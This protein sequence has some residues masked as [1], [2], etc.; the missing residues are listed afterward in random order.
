[1]IEE[2]ESKYISLREAT[3][4]CKHSQEY[5][6]LRV[7]QGKL[8]ALKFGRNWVTKKEWLEDYLKKVDEYNI[9]INAKKIISPPETLPIRKKPAL[10]LALKSVTGLRFGFVVALT[11][12]LLTTGVVFGK[13]SLRNTFKNLNHYVAELNQSFDKLVFVDLVSAGKKTASNFESFANDIP[14]KIRDAKEL[15]HWLTAMTFG[16][17][18]DYSFEIFKDYGKWLSEAT[19][20]TAKKIAK[21]P[22]IVSDFVGEKLQN[23]SRNTFEGLKSL[24]G[25]IKKIP[26]IVDDSFKNLSK[27]AK[28]SAENLVELIKRIPQIVSQSFRN[29]LKTALEGGKYLVESIKK[30]PQTISQAFKK[31]V[32]RE[33][34]VEKK[35]SE[36]EIEEMK[37]EIKAIK[38]KGLQVREITKEVSRITQIEP[39]KEIT[40]EKIISKIDEESLRILNV[41]IADLQTEVAK[42]LY[43]PGGVIS[44]QIYITQP[45]ASPKIY[46][47]NADIV[48]QAAGSG[49]VILSAAT[50]M[51]ISGSQVVI[52]STSATN[53]LVYIA[54]K[55][56]IDG[57]TEILG[58]LSSGNL[59]AGT[60]VFNAASD[61]TGKVL[62]VQVGG[63]T[64]FSVDNAGAITFT[65]DL[66][67][68]DD[69][70][71]T[72]KL[73]I[74]T[75][76]PTEMLTIVGTSTT[77]LLGVYSSSSAP[78]LYVDTNGNVGIGTSTPGALLHSLSAGTTQL[79]LGYDSSNYQ[80]FTVQSDGSL[81][82]AQDGGS[83]TLALTNGSVGIGTTSPSALLDV[84]SDNSSASGLFRVATGTTEGL[85]VDAAGYVGIGTTSPAYNLT[86]DGQCVTGDTLLPILGVRISDVNLVQIKDIKGGEYVL[87]LNEK[88]G[89]LEPARIKGLLD[90]GVKPIYQLETED[91]KTI[92]T[93]GNHPYLVVQN[94]KSAKMTDSSG[95]SNLAWNSGLPTYSQYS[96]SENLV[97]SFTVDN[98]KALE[99]G[100]IEPPDSWMAIPSPYQVTPRAL[101]LY[102]DDLSWATWTKVIYLEA[103]DEIA[104]A[105]DDLKN[106]EFVKIAK[107]EI[108]AAE[109]VYDIEVEGTHNFVANG[110]IAHN[111]Y[112]SATTTIMGNVGIGTTS[113]SALLDLFRPSTGNIFA[114]S[115]TTAGDLVTIDN[116]GNVGI[117]TTSPS[118]LLDVFSDNSSATGLFRVATGT[119]EGLY[120][121]TAGNVG[122][123]TTTPSANLTLKQQN[124]ADTMILAVRQ[125]DS[126]PSGDFIKYQ[127]V[128]GTDLFRVDN[129][130]NVYQ[131]GIIQSSGSLTITSSSTPQF[132]V[133]QDSSEIT[134]TVSTGGTTTVAVNAPSSPS[135]TFVPQSNSVNTFS[136]ADASENSILSIDTSNR[137]VG[138]GTTSP[139][140]L[141]DVF[142]DGS[143]ASGLF[144]VAT[145]TTEGLYVDTAG[146]VGIGTTSPGAILEVFSDSSSATGL[147][148]VA[149]GTTEAMYITTAGNVGIGTTTPLALLEVFSDN[150][151]ASG[152]FRVATGTTE[153][154]YVD[155]SG[156]VGIGTTSPSALLEVFSDNSSA[157]GLLRVA[158]GTTE[159]LYVDI[160][161]NVGI[162]TAGPGA[163]LDV[164]ISVGSDTAG[165]GGALILGYDN[166]YWI[167]RE[168][169]T[170]LADLAIDRLYGGTNYE[171]MRIQRSTGNV[172]IGTV[173][174]NYKLD[175]NGTIRTNSTFYATTTD[176]D[177][178]TVNSSLSF[179]DNSVAEAD[180]NFSTS[181]G[182]GNHLYISGGNLACEADDDVPESA[183]FDALIRY[184]SFTYSTSTAWTASTTI[185]LGTAYVAETW[186]G[187]QCFTDAGTL[188]V[189][190]ND[191]TNKMN[192]FNA[193]T[194][195]GTVGLTTNNSFT[196]GEKRYVIIGTPATLPT[197]I[198]CT[199]KKTITGD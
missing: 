94:K 14:N 168:S 82:I 100:G 124:N 172:G 60:A 146:N 67:G 117:G 34:I 150:S 19:S 175:V 47:E 148:R 53:P 179:P 80:D 151:S 25:S 197:K 152:L 70:T 134:F 44:Q 105:A 57:N 33:I 157:T 2:K 20:N 18:R 145:G 95:V 43:A 49:S 62:D 16:E 32:L 110:I 7:R 160:A 136:F 72:G 29:L 74:N 119:I 138:I 15:S 166:P 12:V 1:M 13:E 79:R 198:S 48:L 108:L 156:N 28:Q 42:R 99:V 40:Y 143:S 31:E 102:Q 37:G 163:K 183:D 111:T 173:S 128:S 92:R 186:S 155:V 187:V 121:D 83:A 126:A 9:Q 50:G 54:D 24:A 140:A 164:R 177:I 120:V 59:T 199:I 191:D 84:F 3:Q 39:V 170:P 130:G 10:R 112:I 115:S 101:S 30:L 56:R 4:Y 176:T 193:S 21:A 153:G 45:V 181:C 141:L 55:T 86:V 97:K 81:Y 69:F 154:L 58:T 139:S 178:L 71:I 107:I 23:F 116:N 169:A 65:G 185:P 182:T 104:V 87:S 96:K 132:R 113:P 41:Q 188:N 6:S 106:I 127:T 73:G 190:F 61:Y 162:G 196:A 98:Q 91:G 5:L 195:A 118:A 78:A 133:Q 35:P 51:Q 192:L 85:Y 114:I 129:S 64:K 63:A 147:F 75:D 93:T 184:A 165:I 159:G 89:K 90:M 167:F 144:R 17:I 52:D 88:T 180:I 123:G 26:Q 46:Q 135:L 11:F 22:G 171:V 27:T 76:S 189:D 38:E 158:T 194:T 137:Y 77:P 149:T 66:S 36:K 68:A 109:Q 161:G 142:S 125:T 122:I 103:G 131:G 8:K 174:P